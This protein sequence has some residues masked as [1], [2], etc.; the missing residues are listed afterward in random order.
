MYSAIWFISTL[1]FYFIFF[2]WIT[3][4]LDLVGSFPSL[5]RSR[6][7]VVEGNEHMENIPELFFSHV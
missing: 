6:V 7:A 5:A 2:L 1:S 3:R 4:R